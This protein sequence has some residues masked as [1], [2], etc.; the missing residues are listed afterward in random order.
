MVS[1][2]YKD[3]IATSIIIYAVV[4]AFVFSAVVSFYAVVVAIK[5]L[6]F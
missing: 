4:A 5:L 6:F 3:K 1:L 2:Y